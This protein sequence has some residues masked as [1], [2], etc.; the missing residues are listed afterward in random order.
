[1]PTPVAL[2]AEEHGR[3]L[4]RVENV[5]TEPFLS[6]IRE[7]KPDIGLVIAFG[8][9]LMA[10]LR[11]IF[12]SEC[13]NLH[14]SLLPKH[15]GAAPIPAAI[16]TGDSRTGVTIFRLVDRMDAGPILVKRETGIS[17]TET[18][19]DLK[20]RLA[21]IGCDAI[22][23][24]LALHKDAVLP[25]A[26]PQDESQAT[27]APKLSKADGFLRFDISAD[28]IARRCRAMWPWPGARCR[29]VSTEGRSEEIA[30]AAVL[31]VPNR[32][33]APPGTVTSVFTIATAAGT[34]EI[35]SLQPAGKRLMSWQ[36][37]VNGRRVKTGDRFERIER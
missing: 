8:Q 15:R 35:G 7:L 22:G 36:D 34:L 20:E 33:D 16:L 14:A 30:I 29:Y 10:P 18:A 23:A 9:K 5:N 28:E 3:P 19:G 11:G 24:G 37:F 25:Q 32:A 1:M 31:A 27:Q 21:R 2:M 26:E 6:K 17:M 4:E 13:I 12:P